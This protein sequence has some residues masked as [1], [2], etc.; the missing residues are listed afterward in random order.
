MGP[1]KRETQSGY[2]LTGQVVAAYTSGF[3]LPAR[4]PALR[5]G[6]RGLLEELSQFSQNLAQN[7]SLFIRPL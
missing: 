5:G 4:S 3:R 1:D 7:G 6:G 2:Y